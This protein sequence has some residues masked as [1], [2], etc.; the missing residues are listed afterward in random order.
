[1]I[2]QADPHSL[3]S[4]KR[5]DIPVKWRYFRHLMNDNDPDAE[6]VYMWH[7]GKRMETNAKAGFGMD[8]GKQTPRDYIDACRAL[9]KSMQDKGYDKDWPIPVDPN[10]ELLGG[11]H[12]L[13]C[14]L[15]LD[16]RVWVQHCTTSVT[17]PS[18]SYR[19]FVWLT[20][21]ADADRQRLI[22]DWETLCQF[23]ESKADTSGEVKA[24]SK[25]ERRRPR[26]QEPPTHM[27]IA[28]QASVEGAA[29]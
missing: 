11:A 21:M 2:E 23:D 10:G 13:A 8:T 22:E 27:D 16:V 19:W 24:P 12:R 15:A 26:L 6:R 3:L 5:L 14:A 25:P 18:W 1:M 20:D 17:A 4:W 9:L 7:I 28:A 29:P